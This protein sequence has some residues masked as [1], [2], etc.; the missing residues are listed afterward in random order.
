[1]NVQIDDHAFNNLLES[2]YLFILSISHELILFKQEECSYTKKGSTFSVNA[3]LRELLGGLKIA[4]KR[5]KKTFKEAFRQII[6]SKS[7]KIQNLISDQNL[8]KFFKK[9]SKLRLSQEKEVQILLLEYIKSYYNY[10]WNVK[11]ASKFEETLVKLK[12]TDNT[13]TEVFKKKFNLFQITEKSITDLVK[14]MKCKLFL[15]MFLI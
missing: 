3:R 11:E 9:R 13:F 10:I 6:E 14:Q 15:D 2:T 7:K 4:K 1:M 5:I 8:S 12:V